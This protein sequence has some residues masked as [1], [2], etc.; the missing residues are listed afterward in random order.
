MKILKHQDQS[1]YHSFKYLSEC[2]CVSSHTN[3]QTETERYRKQQ[4]VFFFPIYIAREKNN[5]QDNH[6]RCKE[7]IHENM[8]KKKERDQVNDHAQTTTTT[9]QRNVLNLNT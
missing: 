5:S 8:Y 2:A 1:S 7:D 6:K 9:R 4:K 3:T